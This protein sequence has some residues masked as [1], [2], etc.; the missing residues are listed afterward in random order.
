MSN[1]IPSTSKNHGFTE[2]RWGY[3][4]A[5]SWWQNDKSEWLVVG[6][7]RSG[8]YHGFATPDVVTAV[9][10]DF[11]DLVRAGTAATVTR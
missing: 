7:D 5:W 10:N 1:F 4:G 11:G 8:A 2:D 6:H 9:V 3:S